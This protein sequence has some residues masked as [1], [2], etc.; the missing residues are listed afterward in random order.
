M[1]KLP[2]SPVLFALFVI[3][4]LAVLS[5]SLYARSVIG[6]LTREMEANVMARLTETAKRGAEFVSLDELE[7]F[8]RPE[9]MD[10]PEYRELRLRLR[11]FAEDAGVLYVYYLR[12]SGDMVQYIVDNDFDERTRV[13]LDTPPT[14]LFTLPEPHRQFLR[15]QVTAFPIGY[16]FGG[17]GGLISAGAPILDESG[18]VVAGCGVDIDDKRI[19]WARRMSYALW[20][21]QIVTTLIVF[22]SGLSCLIS[23]NREANIAKEAN[24]AKSRFLSNFS[25]EMRTPLTVMSTSAQLVSELLD[26]A[27]SAEEMK[28]SLDEIRNEAGRLA[29][30]S[31]AAV[32][33]G[34]VQSEHG[35][36][37]ELDL[38]NL[39]R[40]TAEFFR[41]D[42]ERGDNRLGVAVPDGLPPV[43]GNA[44]R[45]SQV[46]INLVSNASRHTRGG[47]I[48][49]SVSCND[50]V[51][52]VAI[53]DTGEG[54]DAEMLPGI[55]ERRPAREDGGR[56]GGFGLS[57]S[58]EIVERHGGRIWLK[59]VKGEGTSAGF[60]LP[61]MKN[62]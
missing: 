35:E 42:I 59:S 2:T 46:L 19:V 31:D 52:T 26:T 23:Y 50:Q 25:H 57:I 56:M 7:K 28:T 47:D 10:T 12:I 51:L 62:G 58:R 39:V 48:D 29:R 61:R 44:D 38:G 11:D 13:G 5:M 37:R 17:W 41:L 30:M 27:G 22:V 8:R 49:V 20:I 14:S 3:A 6:Y 4:C 9:D 60:T 18:R 43:F 21:L 36:M 32:V 1:K 34:T 54:I 16:Y 33:L 45:L 15:G 40:V 53:S 24:M 55:F